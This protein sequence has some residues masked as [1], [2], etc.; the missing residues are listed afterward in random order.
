M[1]QVQYGSNNIPTASVELQT[2]SGTIVQE[3]CT[4]SGSVEALYATLDKL[5]SEKLELVDYQISSVG[6]GKDALAQANV[7]LLINDEQMNGRGSAQDVI[8]ASANAF[9]NAVNRY[10]IQSKANTKRPKT[11]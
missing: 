4:G 3:S 8:E 5:I 1:F 6:G 7:Q 2:P 9:I 11:I 10:V